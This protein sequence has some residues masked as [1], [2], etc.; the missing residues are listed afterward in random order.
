M[1]I[2]TSSIQTSAQETPKTTPLIA[3]LTSHTKNFSQEKVHLHLDKYVYAAGD[4][5]YLAGYIVN[6]VKNIPSDQS[7]ILYIE[8]IGNGQQVLKSTKSQIVAGFTS[9]SINL[10]DTLR[11]GAY[12]IR[13]Y[14]NWMRNFDN[15]FFFTREISILNQ[16]I[17]A[18][19]INSKVQIPANQLAESKVTV[20]Q[21][22]AN[23]KVA[24]TYEVGFYPEGGQ[25]VNGLESRVGFKAVDRQGK[26]ISVKG[27]V[28]DGSGRQMADFVSGHAG[29]GMF[30]LKPDYSQTYTALVTLP[31][32]R[33]QEIKLPV[34]AQSGYIITADNSN[35]DTLHITLQTTADLVKKRKMTFL[36]LSNGVPLF[37]METDLPDRQV[38]ISVPKS[39][40]PGGIIQLSLINDLY[41]PVS[42]RLVFNKYLESVNLNV[43]G[44][45]PSY[46]KGEDVVLEL[47]TKDQLGKPMMGSFSVSVTQSID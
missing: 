43:S 37:Y 25:L 7:K 3:N 15:R 5:I 6:A 11:E 8:L 30:K 10:P 40:L 46:Q 42:E 16:S 28:L 24:T 18:R 34:V 22:S 17:I 36:P 47:D 2:L 1:L 29:L 27:I 38:Y 9:A 13:A 26:G 19:S 33:N 41:Q 31:D 14:T 12:Q 39:K 23:G 32:G 20:V 35:P 44:L 4:T 21:N 45:K